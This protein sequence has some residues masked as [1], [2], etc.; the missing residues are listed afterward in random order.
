MAPAA[1]TEHKPRHPKRERRECQQISSGETFSTRAKLDAM[2]KTE[3]RSVA[4]VVDRILRGYFERS[5]EAKPPIRPW[6]RARA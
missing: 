6:R 2:A 3:D 1:R 4:Y 5:P